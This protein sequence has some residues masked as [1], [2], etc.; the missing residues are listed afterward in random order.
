MSR[1]LSL[2]FAT[3]CYAIFFATFLYLIGFVGDF[4]IIPKT[5]DTPASSMTTGAAVII[6]LALISASPG[7]ASELRLSWRGC[8]QPIAASP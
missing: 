8:T 7:R 3:V 6:D 5:V 1:A 2:F 4:A